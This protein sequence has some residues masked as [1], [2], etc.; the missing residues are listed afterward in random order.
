MESILSRFLRYVAV[1]T[2]SDEQSHTHPSS[3]CQLNLLQMLY[4]ELRN[5]GYEAD[6]D[7][8][9]YV[10]ATIPSNVDTDVPTIGF[11]AH[12]DTSP[13]A[14]GANIH[15][16]IIENYDGKDIVLNTEKNIVLQVS[17]FP[18]LKRYAGQTIITTDGTTL[19]GADDKAGVA[20]IMCA[21]EYLHEHQEIPHGELKIAFTTDEEIGC[22]VDLFAVEQ[23]GA[24]YAYTI[25][26]GEIGE[27]EYENFNAAAATIEVY[28][29][30]VHP[31]YAKGT[32]I[33]SQLIASEFISL[34]PKDERPETTEGREGFIH[35]TDLKGDV[36]KTILQCIIRDFDQ[37]KFKQKQFVLKQIAQQLQEKYHTKIEVTITQQYENMIE[38]IRP[39]MFIVDIAK[40]A[41]KEVGIVPKIQPIRGGTDG[42]RLSFMGLPCPNLFAGG[43]NFH[44]NFE[45]VPLQSMEKAAETIIVIAR[46]FTEK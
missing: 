41:M 39:C 3:A 22:G 19:L 11:I 30:N 20:E 25:D 43:H 27:L 37:Q 32:M 40:Q 5:L 14:S 7:S 24:D 8:N 2:T 13:D 1:E 15:P 36:S 16:N 38:K 28:G 35:I 12:V 26:G 23:F 10:T 17:S 9:G 31:G 4:D 6:F 18:E 45:Y 34:L 44:S 33:N 29:F 42:A 46:L 21:I